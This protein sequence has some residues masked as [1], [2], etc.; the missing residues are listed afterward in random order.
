[1]SAR[2]VERALDVALP[3]D[4]VLAVFARARRFDVD[5]GGRFDARSA[6]IVVWSAPDAVESSEPI[7]TVYVRWHSPTEGQSTIWKLEWDPGRGGSEAEVWRA[8]EV[9]AGRSLQPA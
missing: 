9:L 2:W 4:V 8:L 7:G 3:L 6:A 5:A 1:M